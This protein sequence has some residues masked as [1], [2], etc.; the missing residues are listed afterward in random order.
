MNNSFRMPMTFIGLLLLSGLSMATHAATIQGQVFL[1]KNNNSQRDTGEPIQI[2]TIV[3]IVDET[4]ERNGQGGYFSTSTD[5]N[6]NYWSFGHQPSSFRIWIDIPEGMQ[7]TTPVKGEGQ[8]VFHRFSLTQP[9]QTMSIN[10]GLVGE[11]GGVTVNPDES[12]SVKGNELSMHITPDKTA[13]TSTDMKVTPQGQKYLGTNTTTNILVEPNKTRAGLRDGNEHFTITTGQN[14]SATG[15]AA[16]LAVIAK[17][18]GRYTLQD[19]DFP[20]LVTTLNADDS[21]TVTDTDN[22]G[23]AVT[24]DQK[25]RS[26][27][28]DEAFP[29]MAATLGQGKPAITDAAFPGMVAMLNDDDSYTVRDKA[30]PGLETIAHLDGSYTFIDAEAPTTHVTL[31]PDGNYTVIDTEIPFLVLTVFAD[32]SYMVTNQDTGMCFAVDSPRTRGIGSFFKKLWKGF[33]KV[34]GKIAGFVAKVASFVGKVAKFV[35]K[36]MPFVAKV[37]KGVAA[38]ARFLVPFLPFACKFLCTIAAFADKVVAFSDKV[39]TFANKVAE[40]AGKVE[41]GATAVAVWATKDEAK[42]RRAL[43]NDRLRRPAQIP[44]D[45]PM[46][47]VVI[48]DYVT[49]SPTPDK[50]RVE[51][52]TLIESKNTGFNLWRSE[53]NAAGDL[54]NTTQINDSL[55]V[56]KKEAS[57]GASYHFDDESIMP[58]VTYVYTIENIDINGESTQH[59]DMTMEVKP[60]EALNPATCLLYGVQDRARNDSIFFS[61]EPETFKISQLGPLCKNCDIEA[62]DIQPDTNILYVASGNDAFGHPKG[63]L[64]QLDA[65][66]GKLVS[67]GATG[68]KEISSLAFDTDGVLWAWAKHAGLVQLDPETGK[69]T[70]VLESNAKLADLSWN[71]DSTE[72]YGSVGRDLWAYDPATH[73]VTQLCDN[74][75]KKTEALEVLPTSILPDG[76]ILLGSHKNQSFKL[77]AFEVDNC[78]KAANQDYT[79][80]YDDPEGLAMPLAACMH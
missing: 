5:A 36:A 1:D 59:D 57:W 72:L 58:E 39:A 68:F 56:A 2:N 15:A 69:G 66:T 43:K 78:Q 40:I 37:A 53:Q 73:S 35:E 47:P 75:P 30:L 62:M 74:L 79:M 34:V 67:V 13:Q 65:K 80:P 24:I 42:Q 71:L 28:T 50:I 45:C 4:L 76:F 3:R 49:A 21:Y 48:L 51:W 55:I 9:E 26:T 6:G 18:D 33:K 46:S 8:Y 32:G 25:G 10:F 60:L 12:V 41:K 19:S 7:Q 29:G 44:S 70:L 11:Q 52:T 20:T 38:V 77:Q 22:P 64:Y 27:V 14:L 54:L 17:A 61:L 16:T 63:H 31:D 23:M